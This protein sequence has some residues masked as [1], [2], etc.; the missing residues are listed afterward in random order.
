MTQLLLRLGRPNMQSTAQPTWRDYLELCKPRVVLLML[1][2]AL[3]G[4]YLASTG[5]VPLQTLF[6]GLL[7]IGLVAGSACLLYTS[8]AADD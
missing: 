1:L 4:M 7:G 8:D 5:T 3:A 6:F 2:C